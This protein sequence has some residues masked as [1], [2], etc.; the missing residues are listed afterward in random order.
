VD[1]TDPEYLVAPLLFS[2]MVTQRKKQLGGQKAN[3]YA[4]GKAKKAQ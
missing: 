4:N 1:D 2:H 3:G